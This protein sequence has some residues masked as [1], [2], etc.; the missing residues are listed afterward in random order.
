MP[1]IDKLDKIRAVWSGYD[2][3]RAGDE[4]SD[5]WGGPAPQWYGSI[6]P[7][8]AP[9]LPTRHV[10]EIAPGF[11]RMTQFLLPWCE[12]YIG[13]DITPECVEACRERFGGASH[14]SFVMNSGRDL[15]TVD[16]ASVTFAF[17]FDS[18]VHAGQDVI[19]GYASELARVLAPG[20]GAFIHHSNLAACVGAD[21]PQTTRSRHPSVSGQSAAEAF[22]NAGLH[23]VAQELITWDSD[24]LLD[25]FTLVRRPAK[26]GEP[27]PPAALF[28]NRA[29]DEEASGVRRTALLYANPEPK[30][31][32]RTPTP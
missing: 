18:L 12:R 29:F 4:W 6:L 7:R 5:R 2:W 24:A 11:G 32:T 17:S 31:A 14:A 19:E 22:K 26:V 10:L 15:N 8:I 25:C 27:A 3:S 21:R 13:V 28:E 20:A 30:P 16:D 1:A 23:V 9:H